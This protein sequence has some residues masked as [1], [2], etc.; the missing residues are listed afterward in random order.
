MPHTRCFA[1][2]ATR[3]VAPPVSFRC[4]RSEFEARGLYRP[5]RPCIHGEGCE[6]TRDGDKQRR[7]PSKRPARRYSTSHRRSRRAACDVPQ[8]K[9]EV[10]R[11]LE[12][13]GRLAVQ[14]ALD[15]QSK[16]RGD[17]LDEWRRIGAQDRAH[18]IGC[19]RCLE[20]TRPDTISNS[21]MPRLKISERASSASPR[22]CSGD[23]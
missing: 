5:P 6:S 7:Q 15:D 8:R 16:A 20:R 2:R 19:R 9:C 11:R 4:E 17:R 13:F 22:T 23:M 1:R 18:H 12:A 10:G 14:T 3:S 21:T